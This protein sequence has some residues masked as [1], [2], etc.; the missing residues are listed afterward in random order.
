MHPVFAWYLRLSVWLASRSSCM[1]R[2]KRA[3]RGGSWIN[4][5]RNARSAYRNAN[6]R[7]NRNNN[8]GFRLAL[9]CNASAP[10]CMPGTPRWTR[11]SILCGAQAC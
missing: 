10:R 8:L 9:S 2:S 1:V 11:G 5:A 6:E 3:V 4:N 7:G